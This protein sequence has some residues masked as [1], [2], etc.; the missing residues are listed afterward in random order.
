MAETRNY[1]VPEVRD[2]F[3]NNVVDTFAATDDGQAHLNRIANAITNESIKKRMASQRKT[4]A[5]TA[6]QKEVA[7]IATKS[8]EKLPDL[9]VRKD[10]WIA[11]YISR[12][13]DQ[14]EE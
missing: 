7:R 13:Y 3:N 11:K 10:D 14:D 1:T 4:N 5:T 9:L 2:L 6:F 8:P 12:K